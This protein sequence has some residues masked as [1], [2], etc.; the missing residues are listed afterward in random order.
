MLDSNLSVKKIKNL[1]WNM[2]REVWSLGK[3]FAE[4]ET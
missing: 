1:F 4:K 3:S 2:P